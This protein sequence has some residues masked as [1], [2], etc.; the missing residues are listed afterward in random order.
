MVYIVNYSFYWKRVDLS[1]IEVMKKPKMKTCKQE[2]FKDHRHYKN[3]FNGNV[4][5]TNEAP[6]PVTSEVSI[7]PSRTS[8]IRRISKTNEQ[9]TVL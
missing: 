9:C 4:F 1:S 6:M 2:T 5:L 8:S 7:Q 3:E